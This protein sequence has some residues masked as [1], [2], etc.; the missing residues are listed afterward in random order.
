MPLLLIPQWGLG[1]QYMNFERQK[2]SVYYTTPRTTQPIKYQQYLRSVH[3][4]HAS[5]VQAPESLA[6]V[7]QAERA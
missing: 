4:L 6:P 1:F 3:E 2:H 7:S 5:S